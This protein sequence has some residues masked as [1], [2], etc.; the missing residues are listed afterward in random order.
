MGNK[1]ILLRIIEYKMGN[2]LE[3]YTRFMNSL[4]FEEAMQLK[5]FADTLGEAAL[6]IAKKNSKGDGYH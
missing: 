5:S 3:G 4:S 1:E 2:D 6:Q